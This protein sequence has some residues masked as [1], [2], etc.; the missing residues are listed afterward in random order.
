MNEKYQ[1]ILEKINTSQKDK[2]D[3]YNRI[4]KEGISVD[5]EGKDSSE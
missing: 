5:V 1:K 2:T 3:Y 4:L